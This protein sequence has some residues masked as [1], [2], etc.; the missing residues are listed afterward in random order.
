MASPERSGI[1]LGEQAGEEMPRMRRLAR[2]HMVG[3]GALG[4]ASGQV[5]GG[6]ELPQMHAHRADRD[7]RRMGRDRGRGEERGNLA[8]GR[9]PSGLPLRR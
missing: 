8:V 3:D 9:Q 1:H 2:D 5:R 7:G 4:A 6:C